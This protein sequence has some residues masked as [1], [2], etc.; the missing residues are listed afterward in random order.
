MRRGSTLV[1]CALVTTVF[2]FLLVG[3][4]EI[5]RL[6]FACNSIT[7]AAHRAARFAATRGSSSGHAASVSDIQ[8]AA[9]SYVAALDTAALSVGVTWTPD[10]H[11][12]S[13]VQVQVSYSFK[14]LLIPL[15]ASA[16]TLKS[17]SSQVITQ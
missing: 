16:L 12:G 2:I 9:L 7:F 5:G 1:E 10:N 8:N 13:Q 6:G 11:P 14:P 4:M 15:S 3:I 17:T